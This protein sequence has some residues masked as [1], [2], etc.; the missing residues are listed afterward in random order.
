M[1]AEVKK[2]KKKS[3]LFVLPWVGLLLLVIS[4][5]LTHS[6]AAGAKNAPDPEGVSVLEF[7][8]AR[9]PAEND[10]AIREL[11]DERLKDQLASD[12]YNAIGSI[13]NDA[14]W[15]H[16]KDYVILGDSR[17][18]GY[19]VFGL[20][21]P[22]RILAGA[23]HTIRSIPDSL[24]KIRG[25]NPAYIFLCY[26][27]NDTGI[28]FWKTGES[29]AEEMKTRLEQLREVAPDATIVISSILP[30]ND[31]AL[32]KNPAWKKMPEFS[33][34]TRALCGSN[35]IVFADNSDIAARYLPTMWAVDGVHLQKQF[36]PYWAKN[37]LLAAAEAELQS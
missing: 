4:P 25:L 37:L 19:S 26:G 34:A 11:R 22:S 15:Q 1:G 24:D 14:V 23:G 17:A 32:A 2:K 29:Y 10:K 6:D 21:D 30:A 12:K 8:E 13:E 16:F 35:G 20:L 7:M 28:G 18:V 5:L 33:E 3:G 9:D 31:A 27:I 36:Y